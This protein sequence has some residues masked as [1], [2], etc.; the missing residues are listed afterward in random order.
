MISLIIKAHLFEQTV[1]HCF[2]REDDDS[3]NNLNIEVVHSFSRWTPLKIGER[4]EV[5]I[6]CYLS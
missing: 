4:A 5:C 3:L 2:M 1:A 6:V